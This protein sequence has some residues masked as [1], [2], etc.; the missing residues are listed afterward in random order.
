MGLFSFFDRRCSLCGRKTKPLRVYV[1]DRGRKIRL[2]PACSEYAER[3]AY[4]IKT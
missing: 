1:D 2:C 3:R 4:R